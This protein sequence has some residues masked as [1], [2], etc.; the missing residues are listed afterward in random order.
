MPARLLPEDHAGG[1]HV[2]PALG[3]HEVDARPCGQVGQAHPPTGEVDEP[4]AWDAAHAVVERPHVAL[5]LGDDITGARR[6]SSESGTE[7]QTCWLA[8]ADQLLTAKL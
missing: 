6:H 3:V 8:P 4:K 2:V 5:H 7:V 1:I